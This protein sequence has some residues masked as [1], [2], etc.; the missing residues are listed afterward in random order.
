[1][2]LSETIDR[3]Y[4]SDSV[5]ELIQAAADLEV[6]AEERMRR[7]GRVAWIAY[8]IHGAL[9]LLA[10]LLLCGGL[11]VRF[12]GGPDILPPA[13][14]GVFQQLFQ[15]GGI[16]GRTAVWV[17]TVIGLLILPLVFNHFLAPVSKPV[18]ARAEKSAV[19]DAL[20]KNLHDRLRW[21]EASL[22]RAEWTLRGS[23]DAFTM[24]FA[25]S[26]FTGLAMCVLFALGGLRILLVYLP[27][28]IE[29]A[30][31]W[32]ALLYAVI[33]AAVFLALWGVVF[34]L[35]FGTLSETYNDLTNKDVRQVTE[36][37][38]EFIKT[39]KHL[40]PGYLTKQEERAKAEAELEW[41]EEEWRRKHPVTVDWR[42]VRDR[43]ERNAQ[44]GSSSLTSHDHDDL[45][46]VQSTLHH[47][48]GCDWL[49]D[50]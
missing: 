46:A 12:V 34:L 35:Q 14:Y 30:D 37:F 24:S 28:V 31:F 36:L 47:H 20:Q 45:D 25:I 11:W 40:C 6:Q 19:E 33:G 27:T 1:M 43:M 18:S 44:A 48:Y 17:C 16:M 15:P 42:D 9:F 26:F 29:D 50:M 7:T 2:M 49:D 39:A 23:S 13:L 4:E 22:K 5:E 21:V 41:A 38:K 10:G 32:D 8:A 3:L